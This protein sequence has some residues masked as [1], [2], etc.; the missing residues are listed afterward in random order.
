MQTF[1]NFTI[2]ENS[3]IPSLKSRFWG[4]FRRVYLILSQGEILKT[5]LGKKKTPTKNNNNIF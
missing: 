5:F 4:I 1:L 3:K 2:F